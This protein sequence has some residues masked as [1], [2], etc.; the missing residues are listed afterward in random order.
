MGRPFIK[1]S[2]SPS[3]YEPTMERSPVI[4]NLALSH[5]SS[6]TK[7]HQ[8]HTREKP[9]GGCEWEKAFTQEKSPMNAVTGKASGHS[10]TLTEYHKI[11]RKS[12]LASLIQNQRSHTGEK[13]YECS[14]C[15]AFR[16][17]FFLIEQQRIHTKEKPY[18]YIECGN[19]FSHSSSLSQYERTHTGKKP[20]ECQDCGKAFN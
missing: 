9:Y 4:G 17:N 6:L 2:T 12:W 11:M 20:Y 10:S 16:Q 19:S 15:R 5:S 13:L 7:H 14:E 18:G 3:T 1:L 8:I